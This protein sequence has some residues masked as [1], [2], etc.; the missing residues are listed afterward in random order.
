MTASPKNPLGVIFVNGT[1]YIQDGTIDI[2]TQGIV[3]GPQGSL[4]I[5]TVDCPITQ[6]VKILDDVIIR[7]CIMWH[8]TW[9]RVD[10]DRSRSLLSMVVT[11]PT[12]STTTQTS[13]TKASSQNGMVSYRCTD[14]SLDPAGPDYQPLLMPGPLLLRWRSLY[15]GPRVTLFSS[16]QLISPKFSRWNFY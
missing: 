12:M 4:F 10:T 7:L 2:N 6:K 15:S 3:V 8:L 13:A 16:L 5:G 9:W 14:K 11:S 1:L